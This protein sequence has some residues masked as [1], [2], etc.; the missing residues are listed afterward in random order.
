MTSSAWEDEEFKEQLKQAYL[1]QKPTPDTNQEI[2]SQLG[3][4]FEVSPNSIRVFLTK[5]GIYVK[6]ASA[7]VTPTGDKP[8]SK[9]VSKTA[10]IAELKSVIESKG[11]PVED[12]ILDKLTGKAAQYI[13]SILQ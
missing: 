12:E 3:I 6:K 2:I 8:S 1:E 10:V 7:D 13:I 9:R 4:D 5:E 11:K